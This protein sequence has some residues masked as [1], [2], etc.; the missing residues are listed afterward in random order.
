VP[1]MDPKS[2]VSRRQILKAATAAATFAAGAS[3]LRAAET[4]ATAPASQAAEAVA[5][6]SQPLAPLPTRILGRTGARVTVVNLGC[7]GKIAGRML[8]RAYQVGVRTLDTAAS[9]AKGKSEAAIGD[10]FDKS[11]RRKDIFLVTKKD[12][13]AAAVLAAVDARLE[14]LKTDYIDLYFSH[15]LDSV[16]ALKS[17]ELKQ[18]AEQLKK[19]GKIRSFGFSC[20]EGKAP[21]LL[22]AAA[23]SGYVD[24]VMFPY[25]PLLA[26]QAARLQQAMDACH[27][28]GVGLIAMK[29]MRGIKKE[30]A[31]KTVG[32]LSVHQAVIR[33]ALSDERIATICLAMENF[34]QLQ[35]NSDAARSFKR[36]MDPKE[37]E[38]LRQTVLAMGM[39]YCP[40][41]DA[42]R[43]GI[44]TT[45]PHVHQATR[46][47]SYF[48]Q[49]GR[50][51]DARRLYRAL[52]GGSFNVSAGILHAAREAC[53]FHVDYPTLVRR[54]AER[55]A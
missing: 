30:A 24:A 53:A 50:L 35:Q 18:A 2:T 20:H 1:E 15:G 41:C 45:H 31:G 40:G 43:E 17:D 38:E 54:A 28:A 49:D 47:L 34:T 3:L 42:C 36:P 10:W 7:G 44:A 55:L 4:T 16:A 27:K 19:S 32:E 46:Y 8:D 13:P 23:E 21:A 51:D 29:S 9:Y 26:E 12:G 33:A 37:I 52:P 39:G 14:A 22:T 5:P 6:A 11:G 48:E 25:S